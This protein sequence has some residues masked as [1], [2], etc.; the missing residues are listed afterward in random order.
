MTGGVTQAVECLLCKYK[1]LSS[2]P[3]PTKKNK[4]EEEKKQKRIWEVTF[5]LL[6][7]SCYVAQ[8][9]LISPSSCLHLLSVG[10]TGMSLCA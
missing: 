4:E 6:K 7:R 2:N 1:V 3:S 5:L 8:A 10:I 9:G